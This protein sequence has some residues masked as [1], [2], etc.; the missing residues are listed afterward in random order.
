MVVRVFESPE[1]VSTACAMLFASQVISNPRAV[2]GLAT[3][4]SPIGTYQQLI[5]WYNEGILDFS[6]ATS[7]NLD[8]YVG[9]PESNECSYHCFMQNQLFHG[10]NLKA[11][12]LPDG[13]SK[14]MRGACRNYDKAIK[15]A[16]G[17]D[18]QLL[19]IGR[20]GHIGFNEPSDAFSFGTQVVTL[21]P[22]T[23]DANRRFFDEHE[24]V[25]SMAI[26]MGVGTIMASRRVVMIAMGDDKQDAVYGA[27]KGPVTPH[28]PASILQMHQ[29]CILLCDRKA[30]AQL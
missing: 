24:E 8:E 19:G 15:K 4:S 29:D 25:P 21:T 28:L 16:G 10:I 26:S 7:F 1:Q 2:L 14:D 27:V 6:E 9:I 13:N 11:S 22:S 20:N 23:I 17:I 5:N 3:G 12:Y 30:A 18:L